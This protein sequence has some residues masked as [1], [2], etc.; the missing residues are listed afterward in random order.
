[1]G[2]RRHFKP[3]HKAPKDGFY[4]EIGETGSMVKDPLEVHLEVG[5]TFPATK[6]HNRIWTYKGKPN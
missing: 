6:N 3:G 1:M 5:D 4:I 2:H